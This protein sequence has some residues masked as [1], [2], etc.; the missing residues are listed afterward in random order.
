MSTGHIE[1]S[2]IERSNTI[3]AAESADG[4]ILGKLTV[5]TSRPTLPI[6]LALLVSDRS[7]LQYKFVVFIILITDV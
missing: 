4:R 3:G 6:Q 7:I 2:T 5:N 1:H